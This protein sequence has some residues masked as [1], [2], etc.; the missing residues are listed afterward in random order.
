MCYE[1]VKSNTY[2]KYNIP[3]VVLPAVHIYIYKHN[4]QSHLML[5]LSLSHPLS[6]SPSDAPQVSPSSNC[7]STQDVINCSCEVLGNPSP[8]IE[9]RLSAQTVSPSKVIYIWEESPSNTSVRSFISIQQ[10]FN[11]ILT[12]QCVGSNKLGVTSQVF[13][14]NMIK[15]ECSAGG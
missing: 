8:A 1:T 9:W 10:S 5:S 4:L 15:A 11:D 6:P 7:N 14:L 12:P 13:S 3:V 2:I